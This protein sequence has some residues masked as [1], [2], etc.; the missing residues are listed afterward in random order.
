MAQDGQEL[1]FSKPG[2]NRIKKV[3][4]K[5]SSILSK[6][7]IFYRSRALGSLSKPSTFS[8]T[9]FWVLTSVGHFILQNT[10]SSTG[11]PSK[12]SCIYEI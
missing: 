10:V 9:L 3:K 1:G 2:S 12:K 11:G 4:G 6:D 5:L 7:N 8:L